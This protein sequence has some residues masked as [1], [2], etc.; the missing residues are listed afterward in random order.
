MFN[1]ASMYLLLGL[2]VLNFH[3][4]D[5]TNSE[6]VNA[7]IKQGI[8]EF[9]TVT[10]SETKILNRYYYDI[11]IQNLNVQTYI[12]NKS[13][14]THTDSVNTNPTHDFKAN[15]FFIFINCEFAYWLKYKLISIIE[16]TPIISNN[17]NS[18][19]LIESLTTKLKFKELVIII[20]VLVNRL[21]VLINYKP[22]M[23][24][25]NET[26]V[27]HVLYIL[28]FKI[29]Y[30][31]TLVSQNKKFTNTDD[32]VVREFLDIIN[33]IQQFMLV[34]CS[35]ENLNLTTD[36]MTDKTKSHSY[37]V[38]TNYLRI[39]KKPEIVSFLNLISFLKDTNINNFGEDDILLNRLVLN[40]NT[41]INTAK[42][43]LYGEGQRLS[44][45]DIYKRLTESY[46]IELVYFYMKSV[47]NTI[48]VLIHS[49]LEIKLIDA[50]IV[51]DDDKDKLSN[52]LQRFKMIPGKFPKILTDYV[53]TLLTTANSK[54]TVDQ[55]LTYLKHE[56]SEAFE[57]VKLRNLDEFAS[58]FC[59]LMKLLDF[60]EEFAHFNKYF[61]ILNNEYGRNYIPFIVESNVRQYIRPTNYL[62]KVENTTS[63]STECN[64]IKNVYLLWGLVANNFNEL[65]KNKIVSF[66]PIPLLS[67]TCDKYNE[68]KRYFFKTIE[69]NKSDQN[70]LRIAYN[71]FTIMVN[72]KCVNDTRNVEN[73]QRVA[74]QNMAELNRYAIKYC[75]ETEQ[76]HGFLIQHNLSEV[77]LQDPET[78]KLQISTYL[79]VPLQSLDVDILPV[80][81]YFDLG[82]LYYAHVQDSKVVEKFGEFIKFNWKGEFGDIHHIYK[83]ASSNIA[84]NYRFLYAFYDVIFKM[85]LVA[86]FYEIKNVYNNYLKTENVSAV[87]VEDAKTYTEIVDSFSEKV[88]PKTMRP[89]VAR[90]KGFANEL[91]SP[92]ITENYVKF[93]FNRFEEEFM[94]HFIN[95]ENEKKEN[96]GTS[97]SLI[98][99]S[100][101]IKFITDEVNESVRKL[102]KKYL[103]LHRPNENEQVWGEYLSI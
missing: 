37:V 33:T 102:Y 84:I 90:L 40:D 94:E 65:L 82:Q 79:N 27:L 73:L 57:T 31:K 76:N 38:E 4:G 52:I 10:P 63:I 87:P 95:I 16:T 7:R 41:L 20:D 25:S 18:N 11:K 12:V 32:I 36:V 86:Y 29:I 92:Q 15:A 17:A 6:E 89:F 59:F 88:F 53:E 13:I 96:I 50:Q 97:V 34:N 101:N 99:F 81:S 85:Y 42:I 103:L 35:P 30:F 67:V 83:I 64:Y 3:F 98:K 62:E 69:A 72:V 48:I 68:I 80:H 60:E 70:I 77:D 23:Y 28:Q 78:I 49:L 56:Y 2:N 91:L 74:F 55:I 9:V 100:D 43:V 21:N 5:S 22:Q 39:F 24:L 46:D 14:C 54:M 61:K 8:D 44:L 19:D 93:K 71:A 1:S 58:V 45:K 47:L 66:R 26:T 51:S 75:R